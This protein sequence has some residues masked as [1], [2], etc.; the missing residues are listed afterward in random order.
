MSFD[1]NEEA[2]DILEDGNFE[3]VIVVT[4]DRNDRINLFTRWRDPNR[5]TI[6]ADIIG[7][8]A[9]VLEIGID[10]VNTYPL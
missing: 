5:S 8:I 10:V 1:G 2:L 4:V 7:R 9:K 3:A 6:S